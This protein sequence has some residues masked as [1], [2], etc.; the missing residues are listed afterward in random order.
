MEHM[1]QSGQH[2]NPTDDSRQRVRI[3]FMDDDSLIR[4]VAAKMIISLGH[5]VVCA[6]RGE[7]AIEKLEHA[8]KTG[9]LFHVVIL[10]L[11]IGD[12]MGG[13]ETIRKMRNIDPWIKAVVSSGHTDTPEVLDYASYGFDAFLA[14]PYRTDDL[15]KILNTILA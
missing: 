9:K 10:D 11:I 12:G 2:S 14:K 6:E 5:E 15:A 7:E 4:T 3:L 8:V 13:T 1:D